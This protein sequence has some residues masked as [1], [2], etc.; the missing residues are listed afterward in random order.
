MR[1]AHCA[2][3]ARR[4]LTGTWFRAVRPQYYASALAFARTAA[5]PGRFNPGTP[6]RPRFPVL[7]LAE[8]QTVALFE[9]D[10]IVGSPLPGQVALPNPQHAW[11]VLNVEVQLNRVVDLSQGSQRRLI[12]TTAQE[13]TG[14]WRG[15]AARNPNANSGPPF[16]T[17]IPTQRLGAALLSVRGVEWFLSY[18]AKAPNR[19]TLALFPTKLRQSRSFVRFTDPATGQ[20]HSIP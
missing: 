1:L 6:T 12:R 19:R 15:Y 3:L 20:V 2:R 16:W 5:Q 13:L 10:A 7:Y 17:R 4:P 14:D 9:V 18:S 11:V 8:D